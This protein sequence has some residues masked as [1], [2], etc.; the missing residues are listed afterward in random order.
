MHLVKFLT[1]VRIA[2]VAFD[3]RLCWVPDH[4]EEQHEL[5][6]LEIKSPLYVC[7]LLFIGI[8]MWDYC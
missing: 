5:S 1:H 3:C 2:H 7:G 4:C 6:S 8:L